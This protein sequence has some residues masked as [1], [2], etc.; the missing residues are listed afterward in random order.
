[1]IAMNLVK[2]VATGHGFR[3]PRNMTHATLQTQNRIKCRPN[4]QFDLFRHALCDS[5]EKTCMVNL[6]APSKGFFEHPK[7]E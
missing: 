4:N 3:I 7:K 2:Q 1:M 5:Q 6:V